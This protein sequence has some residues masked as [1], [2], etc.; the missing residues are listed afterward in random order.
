MTLQRERAGHQFQLQPISEAVRIRFVASGHPRRQGSYYSVGIKIQPLGFSLVPYCPPA[1]SPPRN[2]CPLGAHGHY[3][4][5][6]LGLPLFLAWVH[7]TTDSS[8]KLL[9]SPTR[10]HVPLRAAAVSWVGAGN[11]FKICEDNSGANYND[12]VC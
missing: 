4:C 6:C 1:D 8:T 10:L 12:I 9:L 5:S 11:L 2:G 7:I 3:A